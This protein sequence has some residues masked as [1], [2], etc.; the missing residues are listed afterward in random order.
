MATGSEIAIDW[1]DGGAYAP[2]VDAHRAL[3]AWEWLRRDAGYRAAATRGPPVP[4]IDRSRNAATFGL[5]RFEAPSRAVPQARPLWRAD[6]YPPVLAVGPA[7]GGDAADRFALE[8]WNEA[9]TLVT[10]DEDEHLLLSD[11]FR[12][13]RLDGPAGLFSGRPACLRYQLQGLVSAQ[14]KVLTLQ[15]FLDFC[16]TGRFARGLYPR[17]LRARRWI[18]MLRTWDALAEGARQR[19]IAEFLF[20]RPTREPDWRSANPSVRLQTQRLVRSARALAAGGWRRL[21]AD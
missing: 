18:L 1:R 7:S 17:E 2:L 21:L 16:R 4:A 8:R 13:V 3:F 10:G 14:P 11:G 19:E 20:G 9:A 6:A 5:V 15:R 12:A